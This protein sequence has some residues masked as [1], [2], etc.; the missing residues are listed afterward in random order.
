MAEF[1]HGKLQFR[2][3]I[4]SLPAIESYHALVPREPVGDPVVDRRHDRV[5]QIA[6]GSGKVAGI[7]IAIYNPNLHGD[8][9]AGRGLANALVK[10]GAEEASVGCG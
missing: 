4:L 8:G 6:L 1:D 9:S 10:D 5:I 2:A 3:A 7:E